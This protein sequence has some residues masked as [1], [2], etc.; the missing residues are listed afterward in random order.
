MSGR[1]L[2]LEWWLLLLGACALA[3]WL[4]ASGQSARLDA[5]LLDIATARVGKAPSDDVMIVAIDEAS[6]AQTGAWPWPRANHARLIDWIRSSEGRSLIEKT[7]Y[8]PLA[9]APGG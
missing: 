5:R 9:V 8:V 4:I 6:L 2:I 7:G 3:A 1:R